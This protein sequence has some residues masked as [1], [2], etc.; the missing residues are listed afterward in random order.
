MTGSPKKGDS[1]LLPPLS[2]LVT[3]GCGFIGSQFVREAVAR[4][5]RVT[6]LDALTCAGHRENLVGLADPG[7]HELVVG[8]VC[9]GSVVRELL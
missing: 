8:N 4:G 1:P 7:S 3:G 6:V 5:H 9:N 2:L